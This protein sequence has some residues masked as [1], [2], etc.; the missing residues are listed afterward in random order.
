MNDL[1]ILV[2]CRLQKNSMPLIL[3]L[4]LQRKLAKGGDN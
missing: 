3:K 1:H 2:W 4:M